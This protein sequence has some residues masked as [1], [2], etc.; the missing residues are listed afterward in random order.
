MP[1]R[2]PPGC[3]EVSS[4]TRQS[5]ER[6]LAVGG[7]QEAIGG[8]LG[9]LVVPGADDGVEFVEQTNGVS[10]PMTESLRLPEA[11]ARGM[12]PSCA[13]MCSTTSG[14]TLRLGSCAR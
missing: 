11:T 14:M 7:K 2:W 1:A 13:L 12:R 3:E 9:V 4:K 8:G 5:L 10:E 6:R